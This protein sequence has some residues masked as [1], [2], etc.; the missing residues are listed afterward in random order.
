MKIIL[1]NK[2]LFYVL[3]LTSI[4][5]CGQNKINDVQA[6]QTKV[7]K[8]SIPEKTIIPIGFEHQ[9]A[10]FINSMSSYKNGGNEKLK[11]NLTFLDNRVIFFKF[12]KNITS[13][14][15]DSLFSVLYLNA[16]N[17]SDTEVFLKEC[18]PKTNG[19][20][21]FKIDK[22]GEVLKYNFPFDG[23]T[24]CGFIKPSIL[25]NQ[26]RKELIM[27]ISDDV[28]VKNNGRVLDIKMNTRGNI[29]H[30]F[31]TYDGKT[32]MYKE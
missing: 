18:A 17:P 8:D 9:R 2:L 25:I 32:F 27:I 22:Y 6:S 20:E 19:H 26:K 3:F 16:F 5:H 11:E 15:I 12:D 13:L 29:S 28:K 14:N 1:I 4:Y 30:D 21:K 23:L 31:L 7:T 10:Y 24:A